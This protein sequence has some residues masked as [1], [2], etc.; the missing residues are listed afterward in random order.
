[1]LAYGQAD[2]TASQTPSSLASSKSRLVLPFWYLSGTGLPR[3]SWE[4]GRYTG[5]VVVVVVK[6]LS[7][8]SPDQQWGR[9]KCVWGE[10]SAG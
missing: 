5:S 10:A 9:G 4:R 8:T 6:E 3:L 1:M 7:L 2:A